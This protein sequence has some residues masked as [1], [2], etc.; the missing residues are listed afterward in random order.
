MVETTA[1]APRF[2]NLSILYPPAPYLRRRLR[3]WVLEV[4]CLVQLHPESIPQPLAWVSVPGHLVIF[5]RA[6]RSM[7]PLASSLSFNCFVS[8][9][10]STEALH[11]PSANHHVQRP[12]RLPEID[13]VHQRFHQGWNSHRPGG[14]VHGSTIQV[15]MFNWSI[16]ILGDITC[17]TGKSTYYNR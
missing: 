7:L 1:N 10:L 8:V 9:T 2:T 4:V 15:K 16:Y 5:N 13:T 14:F 6:W 17:F 3:R 12:G 11:H